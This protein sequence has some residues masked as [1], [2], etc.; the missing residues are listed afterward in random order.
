MGVHRRSVDRRRTIETVTALRRGWD[1]HVT[2]FC[3]CLD[4]LSFYE[5]DNRIVLAAEFASA[6][7]ERADDVERGRKGEQCE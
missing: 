2:D 6:L 5:I 3:D 1:G 4:W 7:A